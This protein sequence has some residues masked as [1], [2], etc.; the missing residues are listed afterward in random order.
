MARILLV[1]DER[2]MAR[3]VTRALGR[4]EHD[5]RAVSEG[6]AALRDLARWPPDLVLLDWMLPDVDGLELLAAVRRASDAPVLMLTSRSAIDDRV[7]ALRAGADDYLTKPFDLRELLAR[8]D[9]LLRRAHAVDLAR[10]EASTPSSIGSGGVVLDVAAHA[11]RVDGTERPLAP[12]DFA[13][14]AALL[15]TP[16]RV[17]SRRWLMDTVWVDAPDATP[18]SVDHAVSRVRRALGDHADRVATVRGLGY[19][20]ETDA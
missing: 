18:R 13:L 20:W 4:A 11:L 14:L 15:R 17:Q 10:T 5:V 6:R 19:R 16:G 8:V 9:A 3:P 7:S 2:A 1:E 12:R